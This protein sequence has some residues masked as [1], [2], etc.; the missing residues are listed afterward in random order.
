MK[1]PSIEECE[2]LMEECKVQPHIRAHSET[3]RRVANFLA[4]KIAA[5]GHAIDAEA[6]DRAA[7]LHDLMKGHCI[8][9]GCRHAAEA[10]KVLAAEG[11]AELGKIVKLHGLEEVLGFTAKTPLE[12]KIVWYADKRVTHDKIC[13]LEDRFKYLKE[14]YGS[15]SKQK[16]D[17]IISTEK[18]AFAVEAE[19]LGLAGVK[20]DL[21]GLK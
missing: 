8:E 14:R 6:V 18:Y 19:L 5:K 20:Q 11:Y 21:E 16:M 2:A 9:N 10:E 13:T 1:I 17:E 12:A 3:V 7:L 4:G 15:S